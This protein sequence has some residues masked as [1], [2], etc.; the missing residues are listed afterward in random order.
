MFFAVLAT[1]VLAV[2]AGAQELRA[3]HQYVFGSP[4]E[5]RDLRTFPEVFSLT[6]VHDGFLA[7]WLED[8]DDTPLQARHLDADGAPAGPI[9]TLSGSPQDTLRL[10]PDDRGGALLLSTR[11]EGDWEVQ[12]IVHLDETGAADAGPAVTIERDGDFGDARAQSDGGV[13]VSSA[14]HEGGS[15]SSLAA[16]VR[17]LTPDGTV[18]P[19][20][21]ISGEG[22]TNVV[23]PSRVVL[24]AVPGG[25]GAMAAWTEKAP[26]SSLSDVSDVW[27]RRLA[28]DGSPAGAPIRVSE[29]ERPLAPFE[30][31]TD[32]PAG[33]TR[34][35][36]AF[37][38]SLGQYL[39]TWVS[40]DATLGGPRVLARRLDVSGTL[41]D[42]TPIVVSAGRTSAARNL[43]RAPEL[44]SDPVTE[45][46]IVTRLPAWRPGSDW[47]YE[48]VV[49]RRLP[50]ADPAS[51]PLELQIDDPTSGV[52]P[53]AI[54]NG[55]KG[56]VVGW[57]PVSQPRNGP[58]AR[59]LGGGSDPGIATIAGVPVGESS[60][61]SVTLA[62]SSTRADATFECRIDGGAWSSCGP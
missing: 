4:A 24:A 61:R 23:G 38:P 46:W 56:V 5:Q 57:W 55:P 31:G 49:A 12:R 13:L 20:T 60:L 34:P 15:E 11:S 14:G 32:L 59:R 28:A 6:A 43:A 41:I 16:F 19:R 35:A 1:A 21:R 27:V 45:S 8:S 30:P 52:G 54:A 33:A 39:V 53:P 10:V 40:E 36:I 62:L 26:G 25:A 2:P 17:R 3:G 51:G 9:R 29:S 48:H 7:L 58:V 22:R 37:E 50:W 18:G 44:V 42:V 47:N